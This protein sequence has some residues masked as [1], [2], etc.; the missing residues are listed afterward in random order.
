MKVKPTFLVNVSKLLTIV[1]FYFELPA[2]L[3]F[4]NFLLSESLIISIQKRMSKDPHLITLWNRSSRT[5][6]QVNRCPHDP[7]IGPPVAPKTPPYA[8]CFCVFGLFTPTFRLPNEQDFISGV[9]VVQPGTIYS[10]I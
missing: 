6:N 5:S 8:E 10:E 2:L 9:T 4:T 3:S 1:C 7:K